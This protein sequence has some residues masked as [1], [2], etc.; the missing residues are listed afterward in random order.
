MT[1]KLIQVLFCLLPLLLPAGCRT[2][3]S[4]EPAPGLKIFITTDVHGAVD[5]DPDRGRLGYARL[6]GHIEQAASRGYRT[7]LLDSGDAFSGTAHAQLDRGRF[8]AE[9][10]WRMGY[11]ALTPGNH[12]FDHNEA[13]NDILYYSHSLLP[14]L[15]RGESGPVDVTAVNLSFHG[16]ELPGTIWRPVVIHDETA[17]NPEG[18]RVIVA[19]VANP[20]TA[21]SSLK[22]SIPGYDFGRIPGDGPTGAAATKEKILSLLTEA[23]KEYDRPNDLV[24]VLSHLGEGEK[25]DRPEGRITGP[26]LAGAPNV[27][28]VADGHSHQAIEPQMIASAVYANGGCYLETFLEIT[29]EPDSNRLELKTYGDVIG[30]PADPVLEARIREFEEA[31][32]LRETL[33]TLPGPFFLSERDLRSRSLPLGR[34]VTRAMRDAAGADVALH[35]QGGLRS[36]LAAGPVT[37]GDLYDVIPFADRLVTFSLTGREVEEMFAA[38]LADRW[39]RPQFYGLAIYAW[40][41]ADGQ[42]RLAGLSGLDGR[43]LDPER[44]YLV[45]LNGFMTKNRGV[46]N[47]HDR[48]AQTAHEDL[49]TAVIDRLRPPQAVNLDELK[50]D[51]LFIF[52]TQPAAEAAWRAGFA[53]FG[54]LMEGRTEVQHQPAPESAN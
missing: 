2:D 5:F 8:V 36:G 6:K 29:L 16:G 25:S 50:P 35:G 20:Y 21:R 44:N 11:R 49:T 26:D 38:F 10:M 51:N 30:A 1:S 33:F 43:P 42:P 12:A 32:H 18:R 28:F 14:A 27:D 22:E 52:A 17:G 46:F 19:G 41:A 9:M 40:A 53:N 4:A 3:P 23:L 54:L 31:H 24:I 45:A 13:E 7:F 37:V 39:H 34:L 15:R 47:F 48:P